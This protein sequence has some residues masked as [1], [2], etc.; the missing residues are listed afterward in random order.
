MD[1]ITVAKHS[2]INIIDTTQFV[3]K[4]DLI[5]FYKHTAEQQAANY[6]TLFNVFIAITVLLI[7]ATWLWNFY[8]ARKQIKT[9]VKEEID[10]ISSTIQTQITDGIE[11]GITASISKYKQEWEKEIAFIKGESSRMFALNCFTQ[12]FHRVELDWWYRALGHYTE[13]E[14]EDIKRVCIDNI[15]STFILLNSDFEFI[16]DSEDYMYYKK[17]TNACIP[18]I[19]HDEKRTILDNL[20]KFKIKRESE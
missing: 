16:I 5:D 19:L 7:G 11:N 3:S 17:I 18:P 14:T 1:S 20:E 13:S 15:V 9:E 12:K 2:I 6:S 4:N 8:I 10:A